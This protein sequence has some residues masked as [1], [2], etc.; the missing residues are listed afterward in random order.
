MKEVVEIDT[1]A[2]EGYLVDLSARLGVPLETAVRS[3]S[4]EILQKTLNSTRARAVKTVQNKVR[5][6]FNN[7]SANNGRGKTSSLPKISEGKNKIWYIRE[8]AS[9]ELSL[10]H[11]NGARRWPDKIWNEYTQ[12]LSRRAAAIKARTKEMV[13]RRGL[14][15]QSWLLLADSIGAKLRAA[16]YVINATVNGKKLSEVAQVLVDKNPSAFSITFSNYSKAAIYWKSENALLAALRGRVKFFEKN[17]QKGVFDDA[18][19]TAK[20]YPGITVK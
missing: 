19:E 11:M 10:L 2:A 18:K 4:K 8:S 12:L 3:E 13:G 15:K 17:L 16:G 14:Q 6:T 5:R 9:G 1:R 7:F 20:K